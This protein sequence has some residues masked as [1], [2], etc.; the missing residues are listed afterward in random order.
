MSVEI[1]TVLI[2]AFQ[3]ERMSQSLKFRIF[4][5]SLGVFVFQFAHANAATKID[6]GR[7]DTLEFTADDAIRY[8]KFINFLRFREDWTA[9]R[10]PNGDA[11][12]VT[13]ERDYLSKKII[14]STG[15]ENQYFDKKKGA[16]VRRQRM[17]TIH[18]RS[19]KILGKQTKVEIRRNQAEGTK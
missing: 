11:W 5:L 18:A 17:M 14:R 6:S 19:G 2:L 15:T 9:T 3:F 13:A 10:T 7:K 8:A 16:L 1:E 4:V 12:V